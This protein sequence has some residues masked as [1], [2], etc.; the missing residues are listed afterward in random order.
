MKVIKSFKIK[1]LNDESQNTVAKIHVPKGSLCVGAKMLHEGVV[2]YFTCPLQE[3]G[4][5]VI[6][7]GT[8]AE[9][10]YDILTFMMPFAGQPIPDDAIVHEMIDVVIRDE[11]TGQEGMLIL[12]VVQV[13]N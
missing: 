7:M 2:V 1:D 6:S 4:A 12:S 5:K 11:K 3:D 8:P 10:E 9:P 13:F